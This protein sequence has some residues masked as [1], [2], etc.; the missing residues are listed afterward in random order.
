MIPCGHREDKQLKT[1]PEVRLQMV[2][3]SIEDYFPEGYPIRADPTE[4]E[5]GVT[6]PTYQLMKL[7]E[8]KYGHQYKL[9]FMMGSELIPGLI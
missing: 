7:L 8:K 9:Y 1:S 2:Q 5:N 3:K 4:V 6:I